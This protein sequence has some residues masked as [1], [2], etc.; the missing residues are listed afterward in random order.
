[1]TFDIPRGSYNIK[2]CCDKTYQS[3]GTMKAHPDFSDSPMSMPRV[4]DDGMPKH[5]GSP[6]VGHDGGYDPNNGRGGRMRRAMF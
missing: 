4:S 5:F 2:P 3:D 6:I 1:M